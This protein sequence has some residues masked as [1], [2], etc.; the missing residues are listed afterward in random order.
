[1]SR[2]QNEMVSIDAALF[3]LQKKKK[4]DFVFLSV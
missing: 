4:F 2:E 1:M 3:G